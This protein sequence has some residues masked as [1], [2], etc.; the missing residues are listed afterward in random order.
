MSKI[1]ILGGY[2]GYTGKLLA[3]YLL[4]ETEAEIVIAGR[5]LDKAQRVVHDPVRLRP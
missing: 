2:G 3:K 1:L 4:A 5:S